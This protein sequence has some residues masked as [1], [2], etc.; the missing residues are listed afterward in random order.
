MYVRVP[1]LFLHVCT[2]VFVCTCG[3]ACL[4]GG[5]PSMGFS[6]VWDGRELIIHLFLETP[7]PPLVHAHAR[8]TH[9]NADAHTHR[10]GC[11]HAPLHT[12]THTHPPTQS[13]LCSQ[14]Y[15]NPSPGTLTQCFFCC[16]FSPFLAE[17]VVHEVPSFTPAHRFQ[18]CLRLPPR[19]EGEYRLLW[20]RGRCHPVNT[21]KKT[22]RT[23][24]F[25]L[26]SDLGVRLLHIW[27]WIYI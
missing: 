15:T 18:I 24:T 13:A 9:P 3:C 2:C 27:L 26:S 1:G 23:F 12:H 5:F 19:E 8:H 20:V 22:A 10:L 17:A 6:M 7:T 21:R 25:W 11:T 16:C 14:L 4:K